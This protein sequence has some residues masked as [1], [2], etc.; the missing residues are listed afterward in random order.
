MNISNGALNT[1]FTVVEVVQKAPLRREPVP[2]DRQDS[3]EVLGRGIADCLSRPSGE[4]VSEV[5]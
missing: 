4:R 3:P 1:Q 5:R 2:L